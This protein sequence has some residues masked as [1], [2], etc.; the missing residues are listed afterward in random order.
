[1]GTY[2]QDWASYQ[3]AQPSTSG[4]G[5]AFVKITEGLSYI[6][7]LW[8]SQRDHAKANGLVWGAYHYPHMANDP[9]A[10]ADYFLKQVAW[11]PG[12]LVVLDWEGYD[13]ANASVPKA[14][15]AAYK[16]AWLRY[17]KA[18]L[19]NNRVGMYA[20]TDYWR[21]VDKTGYFGDFLWIA[22]ANRSAGDPGI[23]APWVF[24]QYSEAGGLDRDFC[25]LDA[26][27]LRAWALG[28][29]PQQEDDMTPGDVWSYTHGD[30]PDVHQTLANAASQAAAASAG[31]S[32]LGKKLD[33]LAATVSSLATTGASDAQMQALAT[34]IAANQA[35]A[36]AIAAKVA[37]NIASRLAN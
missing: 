36:D 5:F 9:R 19:P 35:L 8:V 29:Q 12:D 22:T 17:V 3:S 2:G 33:A 20:N 30:Q 18:K 6:N 24:H 37:A 32:A 23:A 14:T 21:N 28:T 16:D 34:A 4:L 27:A 26:A 10:E 1:M 13:P 15:Q 7:P 31:V 25:H 11:A